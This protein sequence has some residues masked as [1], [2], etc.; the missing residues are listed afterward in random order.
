MVTSGDLRL[1]IVEAILV[2]EVLRG[3]SV[4]GP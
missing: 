4:T 3:E 2:T 1:M